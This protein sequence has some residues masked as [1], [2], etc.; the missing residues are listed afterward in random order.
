MK[1]LYY[2]FLKVIT[3]NLVLYQFIQFLGLFILGGGLY[4]L[5]GYIAHRENFYKWS[6]D[7][8]MALNTSILF[9]A[10]GLVLFLI[11]V[12]IKKQERRIDVLEKFIR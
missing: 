5:L 7:V 3:Y 6:N 2:K 10:V 8:G 11:M 1:K 4:A 12:Y 9:V